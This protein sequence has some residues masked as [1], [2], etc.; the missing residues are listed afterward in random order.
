M[1][2]WLDTCPARCVQPPLWGVLLLLTD[3]NPPP[4]HLAPCYLSSA[5][6]SHTNMCVPIQDLG[7]R[8]SHWGAAAPTTAIMLPLKSLNAEDPARTWPHLSTYFSTCLFFT[9]AVQQA[10]ALL[11]GVWV[12]RS[13]ALQL[14]SMFTQNDGYSLSCTPPSECVKFSRAAMQPGPRRC[15]LC[16]SGH[17]LQGLLHSPASCHWH[18]DRFPLVAPSSHL[19]HDPHFGAHCDDHST[20]CRTRRPACN[21]GRCHR[22]IECGGGKPN[23][24]SCVCRIPCS[25]Q[26]FFVTGRC[27]W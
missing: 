27:L 12:P 24:H 3:H 1:T 22:D 25:G 8:G 10:R 5:H 9:R 11:W 6:H 13:V 16:G 14:L 18:R 26:S 23:V 20:G 17:R 2:R 15:G 7:S 21:P 4:H 19:H